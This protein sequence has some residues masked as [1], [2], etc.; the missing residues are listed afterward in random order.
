MG[1]FSR[2]TSAA[3]LLA[4]IALVS[5]A[6]A[7]VNAPQSGWYSGN[8]LLGPNTLRDISCAGP[9][10]YAAGDFGTLLK[11]K[12]SGS[13]WTGIVT[14]LTLDLARVRLAGGSASHVVVGG[15]CSVRRSNDGGE[16]F[17]RLPFTARDTG[18]TDGVASFSFPTMN[19]GYLLLG[20]G[21]LLLTSDGGRTFT[22]RTPLP[23]QQGLD[24][25]CTAERTC[26]A[27]GTTGGVQRTEDGGVSWTQVANYG[28]LDALG[29]ADAQTLYATGTF[30]MLLKSTDGGA[31]WTRKGDL[32]FSNPRRIACGDAL[33]CLIAS[34]GST[35]LLRTTDGGDTFTTVVASSDA[36]WAVGFAGMTRAIAAGAL[37]S[38]EVSD[39]AGVAWTAVGTRIAGSFGVLTAASDSVAY[40]G[41]AQGVLARTSDAGQTWSNVS[42]PTDAAVTGLAAAGPDRVFVLAS[43]GT[44]QRSNNGGGSY[45][46]LNPGLVRP[47]AIAALD[48]DRL[49]LVGQHGLARSLNGGES[50]ETVGGGGNALLTSIDLAA[51]SVVVY[52]PRS[53]RI[54]ANA[55]ASW[56]RVKLPK[57]RSIADLDFATA[58]IGY[59]L[60]TRRALWK[61]VNGGRTWR[62]LLALGTNLGYAVEFSGPRTGYLAVRRFGN[63]AG[64]GFLLRTTD[65]GSSWHPQL[66]SQSIVQAIESGG[67]TDYALAGESSLYATQV[68][69]DVGDPRRLTLTARPR[70]LHRPG[71]VVVSGRLSPA[72]GGEEVVVSLHM[73][74]R[75]V[76]RVLIAAAN[77]TFSTRWQVS[78]DAVLVAQALGDADH[79][80]AGTA[81]LAVRVR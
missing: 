53:A 10:C 22:R 46:L 70:A 52:G 75:W 32:P 1:L 81:P 71:N 9:T 35:Q 11:S 78:R 41:G 44:L 74:D 65:G 50:F 39:D 43:D 80:G 68:G 61:T 67:G 29:Q 18:C 64:R 40:A 8:P 14:G 48:A 45:S 36:T 60:D 77:G 20:S 57:K 28:R 58:R 37:G 7:G 38:A 59:A 66:V 23:A 42:P 79:R 63:L 51:G 47:I 54:S 27:V 13:T 24:I 30:R 73:R 19:T 34:E 69:G 25:L 56:R 2:R 3:L 76:S 49:I 16:T 21:R 17:F 6:S 4:A 72:A 33:H 55:G 12:D 15:G 5:T 26:V 31:T 62:R